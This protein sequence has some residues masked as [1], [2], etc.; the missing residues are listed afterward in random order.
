MPRYILV[1]ET[2]STNTY[3]ARMAAMLPSGTVIHTPSQTAGRGQRGNS[4]ESEPGMNIAFSMLLKNPAVAPSSQFYISEA[5]SLAVVDCLNNIHPGFSL[6]W[7]NDIYYGDSKVAGMLI[8]H[9]LTS[10][11]ISQT[12]IG[13]G[14]NVNQTEFRSDAPNPISLKQITGSNHN[15]DA[16]LHDVCNRLEQMCRFDDYSEDD[17][18]AL[19][20][21]YL[22]NL[23]RGDGLMHTFAL[24]DG[25]RFEA[26]IANVKPTGTLC[27]LTDDERLLEFAFKEVAFVI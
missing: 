13:I 24:P 5:A 26:A 22:A 23:Y 25:T 17:Y 8:E 7:P 6:K 21:R 12:I 27:L 20:Q 9:T 11:A 19:H 3:I 4:W 1:R 16:L 2:A 15:T 14:I 18:H 10:K